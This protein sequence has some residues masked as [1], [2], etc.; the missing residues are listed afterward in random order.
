MEPPPHSGVVPGVFATSGAGATA[1]TQTQMN[2]GDLLQGQ[3]RGLSVHEV[4]AL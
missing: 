2:R 4:K 3:T 1:Q